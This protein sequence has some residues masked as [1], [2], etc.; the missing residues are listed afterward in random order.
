M[1]KKE[2]IRKGKYVG[3]MQTRY[4]IFEQWNGKEWKRLPE[5]GVFEEEGHK[6]RFDVEDALHVDEDVVER[7]FRPRWPR[8]DG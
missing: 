7:A 8:G 2:K 4:G 3:E 5:V 1:M 6:I